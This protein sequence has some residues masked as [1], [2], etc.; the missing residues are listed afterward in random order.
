MSI[1]IDKL[2]KSSEGS[3]E[4]PPVEALPPV[5]KKIHWLAWLPLGF[6]V[7]TS[8][9]TYVL[10]AT[11][12]AMRLDGEKALASIRKELTDSQ[13][14][15]D[16]LQKESSETQKGLS[17]KFEEINHR[18]QDQE[19]EKSALEKERDQYKENSWNSQSELTK[20]KAELA[21]FR[22]EADKAAALPQAAPVA[23][24]ETSL[25][26]AEAPAEA[27]TTAPAETTV[28]VSTPSS[29]PAVATT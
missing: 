5:K 26:P 1:I 19:A 3:G 10:Y 28:L 11:E 15:Y 9:F 17:D 18:I 14:A 4:N 23:A 24:A 25:A 29:A 20:V 16:K 12:H 21:A 13:V 8:L 6:F 2:K 27:A 22:A 7:F